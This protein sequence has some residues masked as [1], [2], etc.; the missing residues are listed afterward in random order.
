MCEPRVHDASFQVIF[1]CTVTNVLY[2]IP[3]CD[4]VKRA[5]AWLAARG[6]DTI[7]RDFKKQGCPSSNSIGG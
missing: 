6:V 3:S 1:T 5:R 2:G 7:F 4:T